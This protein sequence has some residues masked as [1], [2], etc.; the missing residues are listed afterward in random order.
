M[1]NPSERLSPS[2]IKKFVYCPH[3]WYYERL[4]GRRHIYVLYKKR[5]RKLGVKD[6][7]ARSFVRGQRFHKHYRTASVARVVIQI[8]LIAAIIWLCVY[9]LR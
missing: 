3:G 8:I 4:Y 5:I 6:A 9:L 1:H 2:E 7:N